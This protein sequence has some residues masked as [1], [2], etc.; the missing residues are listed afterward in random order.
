MN[1]V[2]QLACDPYAANGREHYY[3]IQV[4]AGCFF[5]ANV[6]YPG[7]DGVL[8][9]LDS[10]EAPGGAFG[11]LGHADATYAGGL[12]TVGYTNAT[13]SQQIV[14]LVVD[15]WGVEACGNYVFDFISDCAVATENESFGTVKAMFR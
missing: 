10:C 13:S 7:A 9:L 1:R 2:S 14:Y 11:C 15:S 12:E 4:P 5:T 6:T 3:E 8:W